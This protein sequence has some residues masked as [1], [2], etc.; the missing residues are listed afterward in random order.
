MK[1]RQLVSFEPIES[2]IQLEQADAHDAVRQLV[3]TFVI[4]KRMAEQLTALVIPNL[5]FESPADNKG[6]LIVG[7][8]GTGKSHLLSL[9]SGLAEHADLT[10]LVRDKSVVAAAK[11]IAGK[12]KVVR[13]EIPAT[14]KSLRN[15]IC[16]RLE[17]FMATEGLHFTFPADDQVDSN[18]DD[19]S[20]MM[21]QLNEKYPDL[22]L[23]LVVDELLDYLRSRNHQDVILD[24][25]FLREMGE[26]CKLIR[27]RLIAGLQESLFDNP[28]FQF[29]AESLRRVRDRYHQLRIVRQD[30]AYVVSERLLT[31]NDEQRAKI[32]DHL[33]KFTQLY[34]GMAERLEEFVRLF[35][36][37]PT[38]LEVFEAISFAEKREVLKTLSDEIK[39]CLDADVSQD[40]PGLISYDSYWDFLQGNAVMRSVPEIRKVIDV[41]KVLENR[42]QQAYTRPA[43][44]PMALRV[45]HG[46]SIHRL[47][48][49]D[50][51][52]KIGPTA[53]ELR[54]GLSLF[55][56]IPEKTSDFL[57]TTVES[58]LK[59]IM[60]TVS[61][62]FITH[63]TENDQYYLD[64]QKIIPYDERIQQKKETL[65]PSQ[66]D[67]Y[68]FDALT[69]VLELTDLPPYV[70][71]YKIWGSR[72]HHRS[73]GEVSCQGV[74]SCGTGKSGPLQLADRRAGKHGREE[75]SGNHADRVLFRLPPGAWRG[76]C[77]KVVAGCRSLPGL[78]GGE[79]PLHLQSGCGA[80]GSRRILDAL[81]PEDFP[82]RTVCPR[83]RQ[84]RDCAGT[85][86]A[87]SSPS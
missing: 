7:N 30:V 57:R 80:L 50:I 55:A 1:Y 44:K 71:D 65:S 67:Q 83:C 16:G 51:H 19:L 74:E 8:Y 77:L 33:Q 17:D 66:L 25:G 52:A 69:R 84:G 79:P 59:E 47:T 22:G 73:S 76:R 9:I 64:L 36:V 14:K 43:L 28:K 86:Q 62:Q 45:I 18:K 49:D 21:A 42:I 35:P 48:T 31:K 70:R 85:A 13:L 27:F 3:K 10:K 60:K 63:N 87:F 24:L 23:L 75:I 34:G 11:A 61:G 20:S 4:S 53:E 46:L 15:I 6:V 40:Q 39:R 56:P 5:Q 81:C 68:Y 38:Y 26:V 72:L 78:P 82:C 54:D 12:F 58:C 2:V 37:H 41:S 29:V 32:R